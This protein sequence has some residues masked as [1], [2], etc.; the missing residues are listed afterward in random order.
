MSTFKIVAINPGNTST[1]LALFSNETLV[2]EET[3]RHTD[4]EMNR[5]ATMFDQLEMRRERVAAFLASLGVTRGELSAVVGRGGLLRPL[6]SGTY[7]VTPEMVAELKRA[8]RGEHAS[9]LGAPVAERI[10][11]EHGCPAFIVDPVAVD[12][13]EPVARLTGLKGVERQSMS[14]ALNMKAVSKRHARVVGRPY[15]ELRLVVAHMGS[16]TSLSAHRDGRMVDVIN[17]KDEGPIC[18]DRAGAIPSSAL[19]EIC[20]R[21]GADVRAIKKMLLGDGGMYSLLGT[22]DV[23]EAM[24]RAEQ[25]DAQARLVLD[26]MCYQVAKYIGEMATVL[27]GKVDGILLTGGIAYNAALVAAI[28]KRVEWIAP[29]SVYPGEDELQALSE[30]VLRVLRGEEQARSYP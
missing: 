17:P 8:E 2:K 11:A 7:R 14:H 19:I 30:G 6:A 21:P 27:E 5:F 26:A 15:P 9:N 22:R 20:T 10:A 25:G 18:A 13:M 24:A 12:E 29:V 23:R 28:R 4:E 3:L 16:G 1:K